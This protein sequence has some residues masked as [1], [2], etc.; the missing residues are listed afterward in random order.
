MLAIP[1]ILLRTYGWHGIARRARHEMRA[2]SGA[3][4]Q[5][6]A[7]HVNADPGVPV[8]A[9]GPASSDLREVPVAQRERAMQR[10]QLVVDGYYEAFGHEWRRFPVE[11][12]AWRTHAV[13]G[14]EFPMVPWWHVALLPPQAD[15]KDVWEPARFAWVYDLLRADALARDPRYART[16]DEILAGWIAANPPFVGPHWACGQE[17]GIRALALLHAETRFPNERIA[18]VLGWSAE[19]IADAIGYGLSQRNNHGISE[20]AALVH[21]G[22]RLRAVHPDAPRWLARG[23]QLLEEQICDQFAADGWYAQHSF[24]YMR[25]ALEQALLARRA[26]QR[27]GQDLSASCLARL[28]RS[29]D[30]LVLLVDAETGVVPNHGANDGGRVLPYSTA[31]YRDFRPLLTLAATVLERAVPAD[32]PIDD[33]VVR[34]LGLPVPRRDPARAD[35]VHTGSSGWAVARVRDAVVFLR[36]GTYSHRPSHLDALHVDV[37]FGAREVVIDPGTFSYNAPPPWRNALASAVVHNGPVLD[38]LEPAQRGPRFLWYSWPSARVVQTL[39]DADTVRLIAEVPA[40][41]RREITVAA[42][43]VRVVDSVLDEQVSSLQVTWLL[44]PEVQG[45]GLVESAGAES[46][47]AQEGDVTG[48]FSPT[49][50]SRLPSRVLRVRVARGAERLTSTTTIHAPSRSLA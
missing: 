18:A 48:W 29:Y 42:G 37:R 12:R 4:R 44:H 3:F 41:V 30:L 16:F 45:E 43:Q 14:Y 19:R 28:N 15:V 36:A 8:I 46:I 32:I 50:G 13:S 25:V 24:T 7:G 10:A 27:A 35:G 20:S 23:L 22:L 5:R 1:A 2:R 40:R 33:E 31:P 17:T 11:E 26:L 38:A 47:A 39:V 21:L 49:Y 9:Y 6:P 34:W